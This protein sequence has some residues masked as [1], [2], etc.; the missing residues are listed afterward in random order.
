MELVASSGV[1]LRLGFVVAVVDFSH[2][3]TK[4]IAPN[5]VGETKEKKSPF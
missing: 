2:L 4:K 1:R 5:G 3:G